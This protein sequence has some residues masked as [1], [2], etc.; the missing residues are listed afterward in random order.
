MAIVEGKLPFAYLFDLQEVAEIA[1]MDLSFEKVS[2]WWCSKECPCK[3]DGECAME[4]YEEMYCPFNTVEGMIVQMKALLIAYKEKR[5][6]NSE[7][8]C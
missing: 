5:Y 3:I 4:K 6:D 7:S 1:Q 2:H 8:K